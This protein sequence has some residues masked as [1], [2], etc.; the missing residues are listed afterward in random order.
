MPGTV[1]QAMN[2]KLTHVGENDTIQRAAELMRDQDIGFLLV[3]SEGRGVGT[4]TDRDIATR[5]CTSG[6]APNEIR[7]ADAMSSDLITCKEDDD[8]ETAAKL[9]AERQVRRLL[10]TSSTD[11]PT[12]VLSM[13]D[14]A[15]QGD[16]RV[17]GSVLENV[18]KQASASA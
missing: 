11:E 7:V 4:L 14:L 6:R 17:T 5:A 10:V 9:M 2:P 16:E 3:T 8:L 12:G 13:G 1:K 15:L 18:S